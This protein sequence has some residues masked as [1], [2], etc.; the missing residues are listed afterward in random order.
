M[1]GRVAAYLSY[2]GVMAL[3]HS[4]PRSRDILLADSSGAL[5]RLYEKG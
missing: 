4:N 3:T 1:R 2:R 5:S